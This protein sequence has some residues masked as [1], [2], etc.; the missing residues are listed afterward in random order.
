M[1]DEKIIA[2]FNL[3]LSEAVLDPGAISR[4][5][6]LAGHDYNG[7]LSDNRLRLSGYSAYF[8]IYV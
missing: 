7:R 4:I 8:G 1:T 6:S 5:K 2:V 3:S